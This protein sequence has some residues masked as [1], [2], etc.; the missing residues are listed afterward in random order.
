[1]SRE[2]AVWLYQLVA[3]QVIEVGHPDARTQA[4]AAWRALAELE[5]VINNEENH[6]PVRL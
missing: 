4:E 6:G 5:Q 3:R 2:T 1:M